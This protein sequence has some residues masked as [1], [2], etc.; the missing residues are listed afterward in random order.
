MLC[1][2]LNSPFFYVLLNV[3]LCFH[4]RALIPMVTHAP[5]CTVR[6][7]HRLSDKLCP[8]RT[9]PLKTE[10]KETLP[11]GSSRWR[12]RSRPWGCARILWQRR[13]RRAE[14]LTPVLDGGTP[15]PGC[16][17]YR[18]TTIYTHNQWQ[19]IKQNFKQSRCVQTWNKCRFFDSC[20]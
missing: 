11:C 9:K 3:P 4:Y 2:F 6:R 17:F 12:S 1:Y 8:T 15:E 18:N 7:S 20:V 16:T 19:W 5:A 10:G 13:W 14:G